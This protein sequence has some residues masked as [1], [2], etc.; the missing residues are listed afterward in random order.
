MTTMLTR[1]C[2]FSRNT[3]K[4]FAF[5]LDKVN[6][7]ALSFKDIPSVLEL[8]LKKV[9]ILFSFVLLSCAVISLNC[10]NH[11]NAT[12]IPKYNCVI[13]LYSEIQLQIRFS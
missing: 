2:V 6:S 5:F 1:L 10:L 4:L 7:Q 8:N 13:I 11:F 3:G 9:P 12:Y